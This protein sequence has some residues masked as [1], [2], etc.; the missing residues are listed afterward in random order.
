MKFIL[1]TC[2]IIPDAKAENGSVK[3]VCVCVCVCV[4]IYIYIYI[5]I[6]MYVCYLEIY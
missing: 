2:P 5:Y 6:C 3:C 4:C 1:K